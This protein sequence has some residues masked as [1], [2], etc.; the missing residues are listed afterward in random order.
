MVR[1]GREVVFVAKAAGR[2]AMFQ[3]IQVGARLPAHATVLGRLL[4]ADL[5]LTDL[6]TLYPEADL[7]TYT[8]RTPGTLA[9]L[10]TLIDADRA[11]G[12]GI[13]QGGFETGI[14]TLAAPVFNDQAEVV[15]AVSITV[16]A[17]QLSE[18]QV[19]QLLPLVRAAAAQL[20]QRISHLPT[21]GKRSTLAEPQ[22]A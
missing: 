13:S 15:A 10:K 7:P 14:S 5:S 20:T 22:T 2:S 21:R 17:Q 11:A 16:P 3:S 12:Y 4:L 1:D 19:A 9:A 18:G 6:S 8:A